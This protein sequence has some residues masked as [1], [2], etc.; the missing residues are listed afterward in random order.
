MTFDPPLIPATF[1]KRYK[2]FLADVRLETGETLTVHLP[3]S[4]SMKTCLGEGWPAMI[5]DS[6]NPRRKLRHTLEMLHNGETWIGVQTHRAN[7]VAGE[8]LAAG[9]L[10]GIDSSWRLR[11]E[12]KA[13]ASRIDWLAEKDDRRCWVEVKSVTLKLDDGLAGFP[14]SVSER[15]R[16]HLGE[17]SA[18]VAAGDRAALLL[19]VQRGDCA[20]FRP[21]REIDGAWAEAL[22]GASSAGVEVHCRRVDASPA[23]LFAGEAMKVEL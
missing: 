15:A 12:V 9:L 5:S 10:P 6:M 3:N 20:P 14:D 23:G 16:K 19:L 17:L 7:V 1:L 18:L 21:A 8:A 13:G 22:R 2:R 4:G 11:A